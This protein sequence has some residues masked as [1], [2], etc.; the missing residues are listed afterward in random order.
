MS[1]QNQEP[2]KV[3]SSKF[4]GAENGSFTYEITFNQ[5]IVHT[6]RWRGI[7]EGLDLYRDNEEKEYEDSILKEADE[8]RER[9]KTLSE[10]KK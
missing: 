7:E 6:G 8:I 5:S 2:F 1:K 3:L 4:C 9:I 10:P